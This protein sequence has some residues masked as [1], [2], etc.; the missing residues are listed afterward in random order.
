M[1]FLF[2]NH[3]ECLGYPIQICPLGRHLEQDVVLIELLIF[4]GDEIWDS[5]LKDEGRIGSVDYHVLAVDIDDWWISCVV[6][7]D[8]NRI[9]A[10]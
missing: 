8:W 4:I 10:S 2:G 5:S 7:L 3:Q 1:R 9:E 6:E